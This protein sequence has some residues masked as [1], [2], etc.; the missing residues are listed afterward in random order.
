[1][2]EKKITTFHLRGN[3]V[4]KPLGKKCSRRDRCLT[5]PNE[6]I[7]IENFGRNK[8]SN[9]GYNSCCKACQKD[10]QAK[11]DE[12]KKDKRKV[13]DGLFNVDEMDWMI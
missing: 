5:A 10:G 8:S 9:D 2:S 3:D 12:R 11:C 6:F 4:T 13:L 7:T 1:M